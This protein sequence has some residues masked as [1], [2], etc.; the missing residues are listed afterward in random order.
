EKQFHGEY[1][2]NLA[3]LKETA[4]RIIPILE[5][6]E[7]T[8]P[9]AIWLKSQLDY[10]EVSDQIRLTIPAPK[11]PP[12]QPPKPA[13][14][15]A[16]QVIREIWIKKIGERPWP[17]NANV[18]VAALKPIFAAEGIPSELV[19]IAEAESTFDPRA[20]SPVGALGMF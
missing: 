20:P 5:Q 15:P 12:G 17:K 16:P 3:P 6:Y 18:Y 1:I 4:K 7:E 19:W 10:L 14:N 11:P 8:L 13:P 2:V 9:Y